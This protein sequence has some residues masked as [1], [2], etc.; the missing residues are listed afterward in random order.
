ME[1]LAHGVAFLPCVSY[2]KVFQ[3]VRR[4]ANY[5][6]QVKYH[7][8]GIRLIFIDTSNARLWGCRRGSTFR[9][10]RAQSA[11]YARGRPRARSRFPVET[12]QQKVRRMPAIR[13]MA[14]GYHVLFN[15]YAV[16]V[17]RICF[18]TSPKTKMEARGAAE[19]YLLPLSPVS[20]FCFVIVQSRIVMNRPPSMAVGAGTPPTLHVASV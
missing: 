11:V 6:K 3:V 4:R 15:L 10:R 14:T 5:L 16:A 17:H 1:C 13:M 7:S 8:S 2:G 19:N 18:R 9:L 20:D 12:H